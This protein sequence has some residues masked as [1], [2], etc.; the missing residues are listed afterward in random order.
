MSSIDSRVV[1]MTFDNAAFE[2]GV[3]TTLASLQALNK[4]LKLE[5]AT[6]G[7]DDVGT[8]ASHLNFGP[9]GSAVQSIADKFKAMSVIAITA[10]ANIANR[11][12]NAGLELV[13]SLSTQPIIDRL[14][15]YETNLNSIQTILAN[16]GLEG[17]A[18][19]NKV[20]A[21]LQDLNNYSDKRSEEHT[22][23]LQ[24]PVH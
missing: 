23:E 11:A 21:A 7:L 9:L 17:Q 13:H 4:G 6:K 5:G 16:T 3:K 1:K 12:V 22:S 10:L 20:N 15:E 8:A 24:S 14:H 19:L 18:G 2:S